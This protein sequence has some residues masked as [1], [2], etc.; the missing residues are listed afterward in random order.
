MTTGTGI[1]NL[2]NK[3]KAGADSISEYSMSIATKSQ[4]GGVALQQLYSAAGLATPGSTRVKKDMSLS[5][6]LKSDVLNWYLFK[7]GLKAPTV[8]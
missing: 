4:I 5:N 8:N 7:S 1:Y 3:G 2:L 6:I